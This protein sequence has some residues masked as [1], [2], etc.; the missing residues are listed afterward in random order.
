MNPPTPLRILI[1]DD[2]PP[3]RARLRSLVAETGHQVCAEAGNADETLAA[4]SDCR[5]DVLLLDIQMPGEDGIA[6]AHRLTTSHPS[7]A[8]IMVTAYPDHALEAFEAAAHDYLLKPVRAERLARAL[9]RVEGRRKN[10]GS[11]LAETRIRITVGRREEWLRLGEI[12]CLDR[13][14]VV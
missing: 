6:L 14:S 9:Q 8:V 5:P 7:V 1:A 10:L 13:K 3:A 11:Q 2:E 4:L 12:D